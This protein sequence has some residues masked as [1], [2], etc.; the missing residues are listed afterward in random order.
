MWFVMALPQ[1]FCAMAYIITSV[2]ASANVW[3]SR[4]MGHR[5]TRGEGEGP[6]SART[7]VHRGANVALGAAAQAHRRVSVAIWAGGGGECGL[8][9]EV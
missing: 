1:T 6:V 9:G 8:V 7:V 3:V 2:E 4:A 5:C